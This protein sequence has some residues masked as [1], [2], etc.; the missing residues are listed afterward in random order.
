MRRNRHEHKLDRIEVLGGAAWF[1]KVA[2]VW[3]SSI[4]VRYRRPPDVR[5]GP[6]ML[7]GHGDGEGCDAEVAGSR[8]LENG[9]SK[10]HRQLREDKG[11]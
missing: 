7:V 1:D 5:E 9:I 10:I 2:R 3:R 8:A 6:L 11:R 4:S